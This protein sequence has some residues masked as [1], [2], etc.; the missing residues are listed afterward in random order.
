MK[1]TKTSAS[2]AHL[3]GGSAEAGNDTRDLWAV[4]SLFAADCNTP[5]GDRRLRTYR[6][7]LQAR[8]RARVVAEEFFASKSVEVILKR[9]RKI[10]TPVEVVA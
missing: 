2:N 9:K 8:R 10:E 5:K 7:M 1:P 4:A 3:D 6:S